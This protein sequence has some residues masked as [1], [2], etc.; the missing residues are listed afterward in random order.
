MSHSK[1]WSIYCMDVI[2]AKNIR[3]L[4]EKLFAKEIVLANF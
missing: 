1:P 4:S 3:Q 2:I